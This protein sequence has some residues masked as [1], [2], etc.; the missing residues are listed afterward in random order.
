MLALA[1]M[2]VVCARPLRTGS[3]L[4]QPRAGAFSLTVVCKLTYVLVPGESQIAEDQEEINEHDHHWND[5]ETRSLY[6]ASDLVPRKARPDVTL[7]GNAF[8][9]GGEPVRSL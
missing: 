7:V 4:W 1:A 3:L 9:P 5:D 8:A 2:D 6:V